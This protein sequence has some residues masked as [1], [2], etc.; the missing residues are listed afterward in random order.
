MAMKS[1]NLC[2]MQ[3][4]G[5]HLLFADEEYDKIDVEDTV[6]DR[7]VFDNVGLKRAYFCG[8]AII[9]CRFKDSYL[10]Y[11]IFDQVDLTGTIFTNCNLVFASFA[12]SKLWYVQFVHCQ[13]DYDEILQTLPTEINLRKQLLRSL[14]VNATEMGEKHIANRILLLE[15]ETEREE[16][17]K[18]FTSSNRYFREKYNTAQRFQSFGWW[19]GH[20]L[21][22]F[23]W[24]YG[25][26]LKALFRTALIVIL[27]CAFVYW[28]T[29][30][31]FY[32][33][34]TSSQEGISFLQAIYFSTVTFAT[35]GFGDFSPIDWAAQLLA[36]IESLCGCIFL[37]FLAASVYRRL[38]R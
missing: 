24:G 22:S 4:G 34:H 21:Q 18:I 7:C 28:I 1:S 30:A 35:L 26:R 23:I 29:G 5:D 20:F 13:L 12:G 8:G 32:V 9:H 33:S 14:R 10:R 15:L 37:G 17:Y 38:A 31:R 16:H 36:A 6:L 25:L 2:N 11:S 27:S 19:I 3:Q